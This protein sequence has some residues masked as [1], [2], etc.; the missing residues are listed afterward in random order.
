MSRRIILFTLLIFLSPSSASDDF[1]TKQSDPAPDYLP[2]EPRQ[3][4][5][6]VNDISC[7]LRDDGMSG[8]N[9][10]SGGS[11]IIYPRGT[12]NVAYQD[13]IVWGGYIHDGNQPVLRVGGQS[14]RVGT[15]PGRII[16][17]GLP[18]NPNDPEVRIYRI[19]RDWQTVPDSVLR[20]DAAE[21]NDIDPSQVSQAQIDSVRAQYGRDWAEW[22]A[23]YGAPFYDLTFNG[24]YEPQFGEE[25]GLQWADQVVWFTCNDLDGNATTNFHG[26][27]PMGLELQFT[28]WAYNQTGVL[29]ETIYRRYRLINKSGYPVDS[30][31]IALWSDVDL[32]DYWN[33][34]VGC[35]SLLELGYVYNGEPA[36]NLY[37]AFG[38]IPPA[39]GYTLLQGPLV[40][41]P[42]DSGLFDFQYRVGYKNLPMSG[43]YYDASGNTWSYPQ[44]G[45]YEGT[46]QWYNIYNGYLPTGDTLNPYPFIHN[47]GPHSGQTTRFPLNG[48]PISNSGDVDGQGMNMPSGDRQLALCSGPFSLQPGDAQEAV[49][50]MSAGLGAD[51]RNSIAE[52]KSNIAEVRIRYGLPVVTS[53]S[54]SENISSGF[55]LHQNY[56]NPFNP[57]TTIRFSLARTELV[58]LEVFNIL[59]QKIR[60]L[61]N[62]RMNAGVHEVVWDSNNE[63]GRP[64]GS[65]IYFYRLTAGEYVKTGKMIL[66]K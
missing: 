51:H 26:S 13:G 61:V 24:I 32:G 58:Q 53:I 55:E 59:G 44:L 17:M 2:G 20:R 37:A 9:P 46:L 33:D 34:Y 25:P 8:H 28:G 18:Q 11:G 63:M 38:L 42:G 41:S 45:D 62:T 64:L 48:D 35:D 4:L 10:I 66:L 40:P 21:L 31:F 54:G 23:S 12:A 19:R 1:T 43:F 16:S 36:D 6:N 65:G 7:W 57:A 56:P 15:V 50:A 60:T 29:G 22:P 5:L 39:F 14:Y 52:L 30:M 3:S 47:S 49:F 27:P